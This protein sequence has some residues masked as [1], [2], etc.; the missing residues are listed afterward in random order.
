MKQFKRW[1]FEMFAESKMKYGTGL[2]YTAGFS[3]THSTMSIFKQLTNSKLYDFI[4]HP[5]SNESEYIEKNNNGGLQF[6][7]P[8]TCQSYSYDYKNHFG[9]CLIDRAFYISANCG[10]E[11]VLH[12]MPTYDELYMG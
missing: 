1:T 11:I 9:T 6:C 3:H 10:K 12:K 2:L 8:Q 7:L 5:N 4:E